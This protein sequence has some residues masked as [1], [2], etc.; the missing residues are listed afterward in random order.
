M[1][2]QFQTEQ[3]PCLE[4]VKGELQTQEQTQEL[5]LSEGMPDIGRVLA[6]WGQIVVR[7]K[8]WRSDAVG[9]S[10]GVMAWVL[11]APEDGSPAQCVETWI[12]MS[13]SW[14]I[15]E[16]QQDGKLLCHCLLRSVDA[17]TLSSRKLMVRATA[18]VCARAYEPKMLTIYE[19][20][21]LPGD[22]QLLKKVY[23]VCVATEAGE[24]AFMIDEEL[25]LP[26]SAPDFEKLVRY[27]LQPEVA[28][29]KVLGDKAIFRGNTVLHILYRTPEGAMASWD[30]EIPF[31]QY[32]ELEREYGHSA[33]VQVSPLVTGMELEAFEQ[34][35]LRLKAGLSGQYLLYDTQQIPVV[36]DAYSPERTVTVH[37]EQV[38]LPSV[39]ERQSQ[40]L[41]AEQTAAFGSHRIA[42]VAFCPGLGNKQRRPGELSADIPGVFQ[43]LYYDTEGLLQ[44]G[45]VHWQETLSMGI[46]DGAA[47]ELL[48]S[49]A[50][51][52]QGIPSEEA[53]VLRG[54]VMLDAVTTAMEELQ[55]VTGLTVGEQT[56]KDPARPSLILRRAGK[57]SLWSLAKGN[58]ST[59]DAIVAANSLQGEPDPDKLLLIPVL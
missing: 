50:G 59:V 37:T 18:Q 3:I 56:E 45:N 43:I 39:L 6:A 12:P 27:S 42:D 5:R 34:G 49:C 8:E 15:P 41:R 38:V 14:D 54:E 52:A 20:G 25:T 9:V 10:C 1:Q 7:G 31:S 29:Q 23:P 26:A 4:Q 11:Y 46:D 51:K 2:L 35:R 47:M 36:E 32:T 24:K 58:G 17:R 40:R 28:E 30:F 22:L 44:A 21:E 48:C 19:P 57:D 55:L 16:S 33:Q 13:L 53:T